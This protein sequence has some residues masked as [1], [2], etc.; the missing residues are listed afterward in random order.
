MKPRLSLVAENLA[1]RQQLAVLRRATPRP[2]LRPIDRAFWAFLS[3][4]WSRWADVLAIVKPATVI[5][6][7]RRGFA[8]FWTMKS[9]HLGRP[10]FGAALIGLIERMTAENPLSSR[11]RISVDLARLGHDVSKDI[12]LKYMPKR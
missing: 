6:W 7:R 4:T 10:P 5:G 8:R 2:R 12:V 3:Q 1:L 9:K 11:R